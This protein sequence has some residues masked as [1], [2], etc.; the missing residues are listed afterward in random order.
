MA[1]SFGDVKV[2]DA[3]GNLKKIIKAKGISKKRWTAMHNEAAYDI[4]KKKHKKL[5]FPEVYDC[6]DDRLAY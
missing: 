2:F 1:L 6:E 3:D 5:K 4:P